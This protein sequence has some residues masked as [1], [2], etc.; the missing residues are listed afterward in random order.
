M[1]SEEGSGNRNRSGRDDCQDHREYHEGGILQ[2]IGRDFV[3][4]LGSI[5]IIHAR[6]EARTVWG[7]TITLNRKQEELTSEDIT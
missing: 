4:H 5:F 1:E 7:E 6:S 2:K 3:V